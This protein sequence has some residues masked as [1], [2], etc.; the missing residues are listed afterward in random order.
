VRGRR[1]A[2]PVRAFDALN[3]ITLRAADRV[4]VLDRF[5]RARVLQKL[6]VGHKIT[7]LPPWPP[8]DGTMDVPHADNP[9]R[10]AHA[11]G[12]RFVVMYSGNHSPANPLTTLLDA[13]LEYGLVLLR[14]GLAGDP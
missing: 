3:R 14:R 9:F 11:P 10:R 2:L 13:A 1:D 6:P 5:M 4:V 7:V 8:Q 12:D